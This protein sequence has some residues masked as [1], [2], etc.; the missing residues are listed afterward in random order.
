MSKYFE[1]RIVKSARLVRIGY[2]RL[3]KLVYAR[4]WLLMNKLNIQKNTYKCEMYTLYNIQESLNLMFP[5]VKRFIQE[6]PCD[7]TGEAAQLLMQVRK[8]EK[9]HSC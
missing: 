3:K 2:I 4:S 6:K 8:R 5:S 7:Q 9:R 1:K